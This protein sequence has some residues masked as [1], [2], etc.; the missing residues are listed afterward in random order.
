MRIGILTLGCDKNTVD[1]EYLAGLL[2][3]AGCDVADIAIGADHAYDASVVISCGFIADAR[4][5]SVESV[6][7]LCEDKPRFGRIYVAGC[8]SQK[9]AD[10]LAA[11]VPEIDGIVGVG[12][13][14]ELSRMI[15]QDAPALHV[16]P[17]P[18]VEMERP[19]P[20]RSLTRKP[21]AFL[22]IADGCDHTCAFCAIP[23]MKGP[24]KSVPP[25]IL[26]DEARTLVKNGVRELNLVAQ[27]I[28]PYG[29]DLG[30]NYRLP[31]LLRELCAID[32]DFWIRCLYAYPGGITGDFIEV[33]AAEPKIVPYLDIPLQH[34]EP[35]VLRRMR[36]PFQDL[37]VRGLV[38]RLRRAIPGITLRT[39]LIVGYPGETVYAH[40]RMLDTMREL[41]IER[42]G[43]FIFSRE[44]DTPAADM[45]RQ[46]GKHVAER[47]FQQVMDT[48]ADI[49]AEWMS[50][51]V[52]DE[53]TVLVEE[54]D[55][56][57]DRYIARGY[58]EAPEVDGVIYVDRK[59]GAHVHAGDFAAVRI[60]SAD[61]Y[62]ASAVIVS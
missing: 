53:I 32:G 34:F 16:H 18:S 24:Y 7:E 54:D 23:K 8:L 55:E 15:L 31:D 58:G 59:G 28:T 2:S 39:S 51:R 62:D 42:L 25:R 29:T 44:P 50:G 49:S 43:A 4:E 6:V 14:E 48:Q 22:K 27:D 20:R 40:K 38:K 5:Q 10:E 37:D 3:Q 57:N 12:Q 35:E 47:R 61:V 30:D 26:L 41:Q 19:L 46:V 36:R 9:H 45:P 52:G 1:A 33:M 56:D 21:Y 60:T 11:A 17:Q 13:L